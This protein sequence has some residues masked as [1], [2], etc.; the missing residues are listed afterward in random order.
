MPS[1]PDPLFEHYLRVIDLVETAI[2]EQM[3]AFFRPKGLSDAS[4]LAIAEAFAA[5]HYVAREHAAP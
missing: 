3:P 4:R 1:T 2:L 5:G